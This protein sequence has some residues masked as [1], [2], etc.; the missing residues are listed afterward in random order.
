M[1]ENREQETCCLENGAGVC[2]CTE[3]I[4]SRPYRM[5]LLGAP[6]AGKGT[7]AELLC[8]KLKTCHLSTGDVFR[9]VKCRDGKELSPAMKAALDFMQRGELIPDDTV[10][11]MV[12]DR[13]SYLSCEYGFLL[14]GFPRT[15]YQAEALTEMLSSQALKLDAVLDYTLPPEEVI[16]RLSGRRTCRSCRATFHVIH[17]PPRLQKICDK[18]GG[19]LFQREDDRPE[20]I[21]VRLEAYNRSTAPLTDY[22]SAK[23][24]LLTISAEGSPEEIFNR[25]LLALKEKV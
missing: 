15:L 10:I 19:E 23:G 9:A 11:A 6:G 24:L 4:P 12:R 21:R 1:G 14:D 25:T 16:A 7:Q 8:E 5:V 3:D 22:Y 18:C 17:K 13:M 2:G 20:S